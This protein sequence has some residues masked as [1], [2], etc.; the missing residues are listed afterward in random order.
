LTQTLE[1][2]RDREPGATLA[3]PGADGPDAPEVLIREARRRQRRRWLLGALALTTVGGLVAGL[4]MSTGSPPPRPPPPKH[5]T[6]PLAPKPSSRAVTQPVTPPVIYGTPRLFSIAF[7]NPTSGYGVFETGSSPVCSV[8]VAA[9]SDGGSTF[10]SPVAV[11]S[12]CTAGPKVAFDDH[13]D[14]FLYSATT[15]V[16]YL[17][18]DGGRTWSADTEAGKVLSVEALGYSVWMLTSWC[19]A[20]RPSSTAAACRLT[21]RQSTD[22]GRTWLTSVSQPRSGPALPG[23]STGAG[24]LIR[25]SQTAAYVL[26]SPSNLW[27]GSPSTVPLW[28]TGDGGATWTLHALSCGMAAQSVFMSAAPTGALY[29]ACAGQGGLG[30]QL[31]SIVESTDGGAT[32]Y[33]PRGCNPTPGLPTLPRGWCVTA[34][35]M[36]YLEG[37]VA[38]SSTTAFVYGVR[39]GIVKVVG[40]GSAARYSTTASNVTF[41]DPSVG[42]AVGSAPENA[43]TDVWHTDDGGSTWTLVTPVIQKS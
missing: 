8:G 42:V 9:T 34:F 35:G 37:I 6:R 20:T 19:P 22:G 5:K 4:T 2:R 27:N 25:V 7:F 14:G 41:F 24:E 29:G 43:G 30:F 39:L 26:G 31:K 17:S 18:H 21:V 38:V 10:S 13:G 33:H 11:T 40:S 15:N 23:G 16:L 12:W 36:G 32:W 28:Y 3:A 1:D